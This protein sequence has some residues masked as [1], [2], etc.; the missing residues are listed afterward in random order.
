MSKIYEAFLD[1]Q[2][3]E[4]EQLEKERDYEIQEKR[5]AEADDREKDLKDGWVPVR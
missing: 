1:K 2:Q 5:Q 4:L 3:E